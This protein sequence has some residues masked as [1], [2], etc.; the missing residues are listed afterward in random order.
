M[1]IL[2]NYW[3]KDS[4]KKSFLAAAYAVVEPVLEESFCLTT[5]SSLGLVG[6]RV[7]LSFFFFLALSAARVP[8]AS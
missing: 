8:E 3:G 5:F 1:P 4:S 2:W 7:F 6:F